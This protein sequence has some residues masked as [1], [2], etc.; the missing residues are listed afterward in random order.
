MRDMV[1]KFRR[2]LFMERHD[3]KGL[4]QFARLTSW[5][6][7]YIISSNGGPNSSDC[8]F[9]TVRYLDK[10]TNNFVPSPISPYK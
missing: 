10:T 3:E 8:R 5:E 1:V 6:I 7:S 2:D 9:I 4:A